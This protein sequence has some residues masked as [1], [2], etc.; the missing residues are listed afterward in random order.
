MW[1]LPTRAILRLYGSMYGLLEVKPGAQRLTLST[2]DQSPGT[3]HA[4]MR[5]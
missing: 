2:W 5:M 3:P 4:F 1:F